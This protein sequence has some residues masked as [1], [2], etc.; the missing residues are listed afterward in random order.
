LGRPE[1]GWPNALPPIGVKQPLLESS[2]SE[3]QG[4]E[5]EHLRLEFE[6]LRL[7]RQRL[8]IETRLKRQEFRQSGGKAFKDW[9]ANPF[10]LAILTGFATRMT[11]I[12][13]SSNTA[14]DNR[15]ADESRAHL[16][17]QTADENRKSDDRRAKQALESELV[18]KFV[19]APTKEATRANLTFLVETNLIPDYAEGIRSYLKNNPEAA[20]T[21]GASPSSAYALFQKKAPL[22]MRSLMSDLNL[23]VDQAAAVV[24]NIG[25]ETA[26]FRVLKEID[27]LLGGRGA[28]G[29]GSWTAAR[30]DAFEAF[31]KAKGLDYASDEANYGFLLQ[32]L[33]TTQIF[34]VKSVRAASSLEEATRVF[35]NIYLRPNAQFAHF[36]NRLALARLAL[37]TF[38]GAF[39]SSSA[40]DPQ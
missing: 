21:L 24:G 34:T 28:I 35:Q 14:R 6:R 30:R 27:P 16:A 37:Q 10:I 39:Q 9:L 3:K 23:T 15:A 38:K 36:D 31:L 13:T 40:A 19:E 5:A 1:D 32:E 25:W 26:G 33:Q 4:P 7:D 11:S 8:A 22:L 12:I 20:P 17:V 29:Y 18:K 2:P